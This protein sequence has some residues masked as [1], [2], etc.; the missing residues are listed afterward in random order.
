MIES[1]TFAKTTYAG[2]PNKFEA[3]TPDIA[4]VIGLG[5]AVDYLT[6][7]GLER[8][9]AYERGVVGVCD[10]GRMLEVPGLRIIGTAKEKSAVVSFVMEGISTLDVGMKLDRE[11]ICV[12]TGHHCCQPVMERYG[13]GSTVLTSFVRFI[14]RTREVDRLVEALKGIAGSRM[15]QK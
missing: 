10:K 5:A 6:G 14:I 3:G 9:G 13:I 15:S 12:R 1:V 7:V 11:G 8:T 4:G 2:L